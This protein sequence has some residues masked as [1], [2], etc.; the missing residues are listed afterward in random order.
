MDLGLVF[1]EKIQKKLCLVKS[2]EIFRGEKR[3]CL[4]LL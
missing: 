2:T 3:Q 4:R 1:N